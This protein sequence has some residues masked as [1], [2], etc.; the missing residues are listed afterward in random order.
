MSFGVFEAAVTDE[1]SLQREANEKAQRLQAAIYDVNDK[2]GDFL[3]AST[4]LDDFD[5]RIALVKDDMRRV[6][7]AHLPP[8][9]GT[10][11]R[12]IKAQKAVYKKTAEV[13]G[14]ALDPEGDFGDYLRSV[15]SAT[16]IE[17]NFVHGD[18][19]ENF[20]PGDLEGGNFGPGRN[21]RRTAAPL[22]PMG[23]GSPGGPRDLGGDMTMGA[24]APAGGDMGMGGELPAPGAAV[25]DQSGS[26]ITAAIDMYSDWCE[27]NGMR[28]RSLRSLEAYSPNV[29]EPEFRTI[30]AAI[31][32]Q[33]G[34]VA[35]APEAPG[36]YLGTLNT[37]PDAVNP[38]GTRTESLEGM[39]GQPVKF[40]T[41]GIFG[42]RRRQA[43]GSGWMAPSGP[44][45]SNSGLLHGNPSSDMGANPVT[46]IGNGTNGLKPPSEGVPYGAG[47]DSAPANPASSGG[48]GETFGGTT[49]SGG[50]QGIGQDTPS[51]IGGGMQQPKTGSA[52]EYLRNFMAELIKIDCDADENDT[53][54]PV[55]KDSDERD[56][57]GNA[58]KHDVT[59][60]G[61]KEDDKKPSFLKNKG[62]KDRKG[63]PS[64]ATEKGDKEENPIPEWGDKKRQASFLSLTAGWNKHAVE[65]VMDSTNP[66]APK[67]PT[68]RTPGGGFEVIPEHERP[69][70]NESGGPLSERG[71][72]PMDEQLET[73]RNFAHEL[74][75]N[76]PHRMEGS[77][78]TAG[79]TAINTGQQ[80][81]KA[82]DDITDLLNGL[83][84]QF[85]ESVTPLQQAL[86]AIQYA[87]Q[88]Q[89]QSNPMGVMPGGGVS[90]LPP[91]GGDQGPALGQVG[92]GDPNAMA[93]GGD[94]A[95]GPQGA[96]QDPS[97]D[98]AAAGGPP[99][100]PSAQ[101]G[102]PPMDPAQGGGA[103]PMD[104]S[105][106]MPTAR[107]SRRPFDSA[108]KTGW[109]GWGP[110]QPG[111]RRVANWDWNERLNGYV[112]TAR[113]DFPCEC[114]IK[115]ATPGFHNCRCGKIWNT[116]AIGSA[117]D[118]KT[119]SAQRF[120]AR[121]IPVRDG[122]IMASKR[123]AG[124]SS[125]IGTQVS[126][127]DN[128]SFR[129]VVKD[130]HDPS[131]MALVEHDG[132][133]T[134]MHMSELGSTNGKP[135]KP[136]KVPKPQ[137]FSAASGLL[138]ADSFTIDD[139]DDYQLS[140]SA[141][142]K[143]EMLKERVRNRP[144][145]GG[146]AG[147]RS[148]RL[149][150]NAEDNWVYNPKQ[151]GGADQKP[152]GKPSVPY[153]LRPGYPRDQVPPQYR[154]EYDRLNKHA[155]ISKDQSTFTNKQ[156]KKIDKDEQTDGDDVVSNQGGPTDATGK[157]RKSSIERRDISVADRP[158]DGEE[159]AGIKNM[160]DNPDD[161][162]NRRGDGKWVGKPR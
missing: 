156:L 25:S 131:G 29:S 16:D 88:V 137:S 42:S 110:A 143:W 109:T 107:R 72:P 147:G 13:E 127:Q 89:Q 35:P 59:D 158:G 22:D 150:A 117:D 9:T 41:T 44:D 108:R 113:Q 125:P 8:V 98:P 141:H 61:D 130:F 50:E 52:R 32:R 49:I 102:A 19:G 106:M 86:Q 67:G 85:Q 139:E 5:N 87:Q 115:L 79:G 161:W 12:V 43:D 81:Q 83:A 20:A 96:P 104:P 38:E 31:R 15:D 90:V 62:Y 152:S 82:G 48:A 60:G 121:E 78:R 33:A 36:D 76:P 101:G 40:D 154:D 6:V 144:E 136:A 100:D 112:T 122:V 21:A 54:V 24:P 80:L 26:G 116:Y 70:R 7:E 34:P 71:R 84:E 30:E 57:D 135:S 45:T 74:K 68:R 134:P 65:R 151:G 162:W 10:M 111:G 129:G 66:I 64:K 126:R 114:G 155:D 28:K 99:M 23:G 63:K 53:E 55:H 95:A 11:R 39:D 1:D 146:F 73:L 75:S 145:H 27:S 3:T 14:P 94:P 46:G 138:D 37:R 119:S 157:S 69:Y 17:Q 92:F 91:A 132:G 123:T 133:I 58:E 149:A 118:M 47:G 124:P 51:M 97:M 142:D 148:A 2:F 103:P 93:Q 160:R 128:P 56:S 153:H 140:P 159:P 4:G 105:Q 18:A 77:R 120:I